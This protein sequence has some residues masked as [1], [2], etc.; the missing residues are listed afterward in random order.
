[1]VVRALNFFCRPSSDGIVPRT[2]AENG[3]LAVEGGLAMVGGHL[4]LG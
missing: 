3:R 2:R 1:M 4:Q